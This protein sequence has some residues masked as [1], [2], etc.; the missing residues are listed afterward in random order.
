MIA[1]VVQKIG[2]A[3]DKKTHFSFVGCSQVS[4]FIAQLY[5]K[6]VQRDLNDMDAAMTC[7]K[8]PS[9]TRELGLCESNE[10]QF[11][12]AFPVRFPS[13]CTL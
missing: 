13:L 5:D 4:K 11:P 3:P 12:I 2:I 7:K 9:A 10:I 6:L 8:S 1:I